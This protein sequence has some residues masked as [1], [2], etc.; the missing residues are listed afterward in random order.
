MISKRIQELEIATRK[1]L[2]GD[3]FWIYKT[4]FKGQGIDF[5]ELREYSFW[6]PIKNIDWNASAKHNRLF[7]KFYE[8]ERDLNV[9]FVLDI[10]ETMNFW[11]A[12]KSK[13][14]LLEE[15]FFLLAMCVTH[16]KDSIGV[17]LF[18]QKVI[19]F[20]DFKKWQ[21]NIVKTIK[22]IQEY[23]STKQSDLS[24]ALA[25]IRK[26]KVRDSLIFVLTDTAEFQKWIRE[27]LANNNEVIY[28]NIYDHYE[29]HLSPNFSLSVWD[30]TW[31]VSSLFGNTN[32]I[33]TYEKLREDKIIMLRTL[34]KKIDID[35]VF[36]DTMSDIFGTFY[37]LFYTRWRR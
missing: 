18:D 20:F 13:K 10:G 6:D 36:I 33:K 34:L 12:N 23:T 32:K 9:L 19:S 2:S 35:Y 22:T 3:F 1:Y 15:I 29:N 21:E 17:L 7:T 27:L 14:N 26:L 30:G 24:H 31:W 28:V 5:T 37:K 16:T 25:H 4:I 8:Q 11:T